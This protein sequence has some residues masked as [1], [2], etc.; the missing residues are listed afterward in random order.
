MAGYRGVSRPRLCGR[1]WMRL[2]LDDIRH[3]LAARGSGENAPGL[4]RDKPTGVRDHDAAHLT[5][6]ICSGNSLLSLAVCRCDCAA[7]FANK[8]G[9]PRQ[10]PAPLLFFVVLSLMTSSTPLCCPGSPA[11]VG[12]PD[13]VGYLGQCGQHILTESFTARDPKP[14]V[15]PYT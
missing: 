7:V 13:N 4:R 9:F 14:T 8:R 10:R 6:S 1:L 2:S 3:S 12:A 15:R 5:V 11:T